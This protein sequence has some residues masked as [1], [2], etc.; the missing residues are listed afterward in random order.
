[1]PGLVLS[2][3]RL[4]QNGLWVSKDFGEKWEQI[5]KAVCLAKW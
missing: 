5:H 1:M 4:L 2:F 3:G